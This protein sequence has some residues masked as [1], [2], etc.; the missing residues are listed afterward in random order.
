MKVC[1]KCHVGKEDFPSAKRK[2]DGLSSWCK[3]CHRQAKRSAYQK[4]PEKYKAAQR[5]YALRNHLAVERRSKAYALRNREKLRVYKRQ[6]ANKNREFL[7]SWH[8][9]YYRNN[10]R[11]I[12]A[13]SRQWRKLNK[14][15]ALESMKDRQLR[16]LYGVDR[17]WLKNAIKTQGGRCALC[18]TNRPGGRGTWSVDHDHKNGEIRGLLCL[19][20]NIGLGYFEDSPKII[21]AASNYL[22]SAFTGLFSIPSRGR[23]DSKTARLKRSHGITL[24]QFSALFDS[25]G[26]QCKICLKRKPPKVQ[27]SIWKVDH[28]HLTMKIRGILCGKCNLGLGYF[29]D[30]IALL[31]NAI[32]YLRSKRTLKST[33]T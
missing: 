22:R 27:S 13:R 9:E 24:V 25:Q 12:R 30:K 28:D 2:L 10:E 6:W 14:P 4:N 23:A 7:K 31:L 18:N 16:I 3:E 15:R 8:A 20:C 29:G 21:Q 19:R 5:K 33:G 11:K 1:T 26:R 17:N 32:K